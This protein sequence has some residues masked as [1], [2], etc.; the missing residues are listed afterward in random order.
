MNK[1]I[2]TF[3]VVALSVGAILIT[4]TADAFWGMGNTDKT[5]ESFTSFQQMVQSFTSWESFREAMA[6][7]RAERKIEQEAHREEMK[8]N[9]SRKVEKIDN[10][11]IITVTTDDVEALETMKARH[12]KMSDRQ[13]RNRENVSRSIET[14]EN[15]FRTTLTTDDSEALTR[16]H[17]RAD[18]GWQGG[19]GRQGKYDGEMNG[20]RGGGH[21]KRGGQGKMY[22]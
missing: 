14:L 20:K 7:R 9:V 8:E 16:L 6:E 3:G 1:K 4:P 15:G 13:R 18:N 19:M 5:A 2:A 10:G 12:E 22:R 21:G 11:V 17:N